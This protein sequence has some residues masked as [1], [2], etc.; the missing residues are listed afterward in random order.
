MDVRI[1]VYFICLL[2]TLGLLCQPEER[3]FEFGKKT[4]R[5]GS[6]LTTSLLLIK[7]WIKKKQTNAASK[8]WPWFN[9]IWCDYISIWPGNMIL[10][11]MVWLYDKECDARWWARIECWHFTL[12][13]DVGKWRRWRHDYCSKWRSNISKHQTTG[14][15]YRDIGTFPSHVCCER[16]RKAKTWPWS[17]L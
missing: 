16:T 17:K 12:L 2:N 3:R 5:D 4:A 9:V 14:Y 6:G 1:N 10:I 7:K 15:L 13:T 11:H 8:S